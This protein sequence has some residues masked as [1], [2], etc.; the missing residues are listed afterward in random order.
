[1]RRRAASR[2]AFSLLAWSTSRNLSTSLGVGF[3]GTQSVASS[4]REAILR[5]ERREGGREGKETV[6]EEVK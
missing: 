2:R 5:G 1:M 3:M 6:E 4:T